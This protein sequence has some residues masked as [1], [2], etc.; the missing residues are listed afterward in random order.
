MD[1]TCFGRSGGFAPTSLPFH[2]VRDSSARIEIVDSFMVSLLIIEDDRLVRM[3][4]AVMRRTFL[5]YTWT[6]VHDP[7]CVKTSPAHR[8]GEWFFINR[9][10]KSATM[11]LPSSNSD[12]TEVHSMHHS[13]HHVF[14]QPRPLADLTGIAA[15]SPHDAPLSNLMGRRT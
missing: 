2:G 4:A 12:S 6:S 9:E 10:I 7:G 8:H 15:R 1:Q 5:S 14:T 11:N 3:S 13:R